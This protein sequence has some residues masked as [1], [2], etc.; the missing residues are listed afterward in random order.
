MPRAEL[1][2]EV[3]G[4]QIEQLVDEL[5]LFANISV[6]DPPR[7][8]LA[9]HVHRLV[10][11]NR[12]PGGS[13][14]TKALLGLHSSFDRSMILLQDVVQVLDR[15]MSAAAAQGSFLFPCC[16]RGD[17][18]AGLICID[19]AG[20]GVRWI[21]EGLAKQA[22]GRRSIAQRRQREV[23]SGTGGID[24]PIEVTQT[25]LHSNIRLIDTPGFVGRLEMTAQPLLQF[26]TVTLN[27]TP[28]R[29]VIHLQTALGEQLFDIAERERVPK[30]PVVTKNSKSAENSRLFA[31][32]GVFSSHSAD[33]RRTFHWRQPF[34][35][36]AIF[37]GREVGWTPFGP[38]AIRWSQSLIGDH[39]GGA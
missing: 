7:L 21:A 12:S 15:S 31:A 33:L 23:D 32:F 39:S 35:L 26:G 2:G 22:F 3:S 24:G 5:I 36:R 9:D 19:D 29:R 25:A 30:I 27:P 37:R 16:S 10:S 34:G 6:A 11:L 17:V 20:L 28:D 8:P 4:R 13:E 14:L 18:E 1:G 38:L